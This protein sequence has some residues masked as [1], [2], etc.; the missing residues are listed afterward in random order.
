MMIGEMLIA[1]KSIVFLILLW[2]FV[3]FLWKDYCLDNF[4]E[5]IFTL[6]DEFFLVGARGEIGFDEPA[7]QM[8]RERLNVA[9]RYAHEFTLSRLFVAIPVPSIGD[10]ERLAWAVQMKALPEETQAI[11]N[12]YRT[13]FVLNVLRYMILRAYFLAVLVLLSNLG[14][15]VVGGF[16]ELMKRYI[17]SK[18]TP[19]VETLESEALEEDCNH[20]DH[21]L[22][23][24]A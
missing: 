5:R 17:L 18:A 8:L 10:N 7:Y 6:R 11:L 4:R 12:R 14:A 9:L 2:L 13:M 15:K 22:V 1:L 23:V 19:G 20:H 16:N 24:G 21:P 3:F